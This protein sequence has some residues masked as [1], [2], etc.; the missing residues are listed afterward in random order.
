MKDM[1]IR[2]NEFRSFDLR[3][4]NVLL[5]LLRTVAQRLP[6]LFS[7]QGD[8]EQMGILILRR[9]FY[10]APNVLVIT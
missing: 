5:D 4:S 9:I 10:T 6:A 3:S 2:I 1:G 8:S 7:S